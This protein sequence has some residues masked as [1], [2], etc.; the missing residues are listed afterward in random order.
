MEP[1]MVVQ[2]SLDSLWWPEP[3]VTG[4]IPENATDA[5]LCAH[6]LCAWGN[7]YLAAKPPEHFGIVMA[8]ISIR[9]GISGSPDSFHE[10]AKK[11]LGKHGEGQIKAD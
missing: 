10:W 2:Q 9:L 6:A 1:N 5:L 4:I 8:K 3:F 11:W 7:C